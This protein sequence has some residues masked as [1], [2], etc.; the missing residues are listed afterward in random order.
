MFLCLCIGLAQCTRIG[1]AFQSIVQRDSIGDLLPYRKETMCL[2]GRCSGISACI[3]HQLHKQGSPD[4][5]SIMHGEGESPVKP[6]G[7]G[8]GGMRTL[9]ARPPGV[10]IA[11]YG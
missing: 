4:G 5:Q 9:H 11:L 6:V 10:S 3:I 1:V 2:V 8:Q 7:V